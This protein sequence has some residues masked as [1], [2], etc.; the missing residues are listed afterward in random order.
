[1]LQIKSSPSSSEMDA[2]AVVDHNYP[3]FKE[4]RYDFDR[5][6]FYNVTTGRTL[7]PVEFERMSRSA[8]ARSA[9]AGEGTLRE[10]AMLKS[11]TERASGTDDGKRQVWDVTVNGNSRLKSQFEF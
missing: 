5:D 3:E 1:M 2:I 9:K 8:G 7:E 6:R 4:A 11:I 10:T